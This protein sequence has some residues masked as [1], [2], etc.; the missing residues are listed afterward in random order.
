MTS[1]LFLLLL[2]FTRTG[3]QSSV[4]LAHQAAPGLY[5]LLSSKSPFS[6]ISACPQSMNAFV[7]LWVSFCEPGQVQNWL[8]VICGWNWN[9]NLVLDPVNY[10]L[11]QLAFNVFQMA[12]VSKWSGPSLELLWSK[13]F[14]VRNTFVAEKC[15]WGPCKHPRFVWEEKTSHYY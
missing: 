14:C 1:V 9:F 3:S 15:H 11:D 7:K 8:K 13:R 10:S 4:L 12:S 6:L 2:H 5:D